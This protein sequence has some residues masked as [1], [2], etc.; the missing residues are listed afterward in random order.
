MKT[1]SAPAKQTPREAQVSTR[2][3]RRFSTPRRA[4]PAR[5]AKHPSRP[6]HP[7]D[8]EAT[9]PSPRRTDVRRITEQHRLAPD[10]SEIRELSVGMRGGMC[11]CR[12]PA[13]QVSSPRFHK[14]VEEIWFCGSGT[15]Q[16]WMSI[17]ERDVI[18]PLH[19]GT[20][21]TIPPRTPFQFR[22]TGLDTLSIMIATMPPWPG[23]EEAVSTPGLWDPR[24]PIE[25]R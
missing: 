4:L 9:L 14:N 3:R 17:D 18:V 10:G 15:G 23:P 16:L 25:G 1:Q 6:P 7:R 22:N 8:F 19:F 5:P 24:N 2:D 13:G 20:S 21:V 12:L 11:N